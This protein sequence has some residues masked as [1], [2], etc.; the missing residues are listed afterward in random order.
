LKEVRTEFIEIVRN[1]IKLL[2]ENRFEDACKFLGNSTDSEEPWNED[3]LRRIIQD[4]GESEQLQIENPY[5][6]DLA[7][8]RIEFY[9][10]EDKSGWIIEYD[11]PINREWSDLTAQF[12]FNKSDNGYDFQLVDIHVL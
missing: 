4:Y 12:R 7:E 9:E 5:Q 11:L 6:M 1:W 3:K 8:E 2:S 10:F